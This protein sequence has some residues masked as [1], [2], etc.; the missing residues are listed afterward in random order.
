MLIF[1]QATYNGA[2]T[3]LLLWFTNVLPTLL[4][5]IIISNLMVQLNITKQ[6]IKFL[7]PILG[8]LFSI[9][10]QG[11][12]PV[13][14]GFISGLPMGA[15]ASADMVSEKK[16][17]QK[18]GDFLLTM[19]NN[20]SPVFIMS[21]I[22]V[23]QLKLP[24]IRYPLFTIIFVS[25]VSSA[26]FYRWM[27]NKKE[28]DMI[29]AQN[30]ISDVKQPNQF[31]FNLLD[32]AIMNGFEV[33]TKVGGYIMLFSILARLLNQIIPGSGI[34]KASIMGLLEIT[35]GIS[36]IC[37]LSINNKIKIVLLATLT[38]FGGLS[39]MAQTKSVLGD[40]RLSMKS[41]IIVKFISAIIALLLTFIYLLII[42]I[43]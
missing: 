11:C 39:A 30:V 33:I 24:Q 15:K 31:S 40:T 36:Q 9:S 22:V 7:Y 18:E 8:K 5:F 6:V 23:N 42:P 37:K 32:N 25:S 38:S 21:Y 41:Y 19:C 3:G 28:K 1:P 43:S 35:T 26:M 17:S 16:I 4:P 27:Q 12:Y 34:L 10:P 20:Y 29:H 14:I 2:S 13:L